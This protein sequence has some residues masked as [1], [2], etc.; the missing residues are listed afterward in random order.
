MG[1]SGSLGSRPRARSQAQSI[2]PT[3]SQQSGSVVSCHSIHSQATENG[4]VSSSKSDSSQAKGVIAEMR[5]TLRQVRVGWRS[6]AMSQRHPRVKISRSTLTP[7]TP[8]PVLVSSSVSTRTLIQ[9]PTP[10]RK[11]RQHGKSNTRTAPKSTAPRKTPVDHHLQRKSRQLMRCSEME[12]GKKHGCLTHTLILGIVTKLPMS[13]TMIC[14]LPEH[15]KTQPNHPNSM[16]PPLDY[17]VKCKVF[18]CI[19]SDLYNLYCFYAL[20]MTGDPPDFP[21]LRELVTHGQVRDL[22][23]LAR[24]IGHPYVI[25]AHSANSVTVVSML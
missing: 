7:R 21:A 8:S 9:S 12:L 11:S 14:N 6:Q 13:D 18:D 16:G 2:T 24:S 4:E 20:W 17:M 22:L 10:G 15:E 23:K 1:S 19:Q 25:L 5:T 3:H